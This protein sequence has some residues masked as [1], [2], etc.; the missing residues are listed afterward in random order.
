MAAVYDY[1]NGWFVIYDRQRIEAYTPDG[2][3]NRWLV[4]HMESGATRAYGS[5]DMAKHEA[6]RAARSMNPSEKWWKD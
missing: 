4:K 6:M 1:P 3:R 2:V 5:K